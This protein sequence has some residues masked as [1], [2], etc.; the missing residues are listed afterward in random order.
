MNIVIYSG[1][2]KFNIQVKEKGCGVIVYK[3]G[4]FYTV[5]QYY[6]KEEKLSLKNCTEKERIFLEKEVINYINIEDVEFPYVEGY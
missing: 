5:G 1:D 4:K 3:N 6:P 2:N